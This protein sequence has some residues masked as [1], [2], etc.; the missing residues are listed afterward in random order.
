MV[1]DNEVLVLL[2]TIYQEEKLTLSYILDT[3]N[4]LS[5]T[6]GWRNPADTLSQFFLLTSVTLSLKFSF[7]DNYIKHFTSSHQ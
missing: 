1:P 3:S 4:D 5:D 6:K 7:T 2:P